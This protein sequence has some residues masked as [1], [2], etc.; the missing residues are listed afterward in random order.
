[1]K[2]FESEMEFEYMP[3]NE[4]KMNI[5]E[6]LC[7]PLHILQQ[8]EFWRQKRLLTKNDLNARVNA[9]KGDSSLKELNEGKQ[10]F[11]NNI[12]LLYTS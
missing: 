4:H 1:M 9:V 6:W 5:L 10:Y 2:A 11:N 7:H 3:N 12:G 8:N